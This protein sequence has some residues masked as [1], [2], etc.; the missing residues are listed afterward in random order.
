MKH[1]I[2]LIAF[3]ACA[4]IGCTTHSDITAETY[5]SP[6]LDVYRGAPD[7]TGTLELDLGGDMPVVQAWCTDLSGIRRLSDMIMRDGVLTVHCEPGGEI[8]ISVI[9]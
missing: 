9:R 6:V 5:D 1:T 2:L 3:F 4:A 7:E 8:M